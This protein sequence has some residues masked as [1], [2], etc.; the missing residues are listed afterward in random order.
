MTFPRW[1]RSLQALRP[2]NPTRDRRQP[3]PAAPRRKLAL[4]ILE[5]RVVPAA[6][7]WIA[8]NGDWDVATNWS[9]GT[10][11]GAAD[12]VDINVSGVT[13]THTAATAHSV[14]SLKLEAGTLTGPDSLTVTGQFTWTG[15]TLGGS[16]SL[17]AAGGASINGNVTLDG[18]TLANAGTATWATGTILAGDGAVFDNQAGGTFHILANT[19]PIDLSEP[20]NFTWSGQGALPTFR[21]EGSVVQDSGTGRAWIDADFVSSGSVAVSSG[22]LFLGTARSGNQSSG[23]GTFTGGAGTVLLFAGQWTLSSAASVAGDYVQFG[24]GEGGQSAQ[25]AAHFTA[26]TETVAFAD[27]VTFTG[28]VDGLGAL[29]VFQGTADFEPAT[30]AALPLAFLRLEGDGTLAGKDSFTVSGPATF[31]GGAALRGPGTVTAAGG[32]SIASDLD[33]DGATLAIPVGATATLTGSITANNGAV[34][35]NAGTFDLAGDSAQVSYSNVGAPLTFNNAGS[36]LRSGSDPVVYAFV[37]AVLNN[38][39]SL[40]VQTGILGVYGFGQ[41]CVSSG[42][43]TGDPGTELNLGGQVTTLSQGLTGDSVEFGVVRP[44][45]APGGTYTIAGPYRANNTV[46]AG[47]GTMAFTGPVGDAQGNAGGWFTNGGTTTDFSPASGGPAT[48]TFSRLGLYATLSGTDSFV[49]SG[50]FI[51]QGTL[52]GPQGSSLTA[53]GGASIGGGVTLDGRTLDN[54]GTATWTD[55]TITVADG[56]VVNNLPGATFGSAGNTSTLVLNGG[57]VA[58]SGTINANVTNSGQVSPGGTGVPGILT[59]NGSYAQSGSGTLNIDLG[60]PNPGSQYDQLNVNGPT[61]LGGTLNIT[62]LPNLGHVC[63]VTFAAINGSPL[64]GTFSTINGLSQP[65]GMTITPAYSSS[66]LTLTASKFAATTGVAASVNP[67]ILKQAV[68]FTATVSAPAGATEVPTGTVQFQVDGVNVGAP[69]TLSG[70][71][72]SFSLSSLAVGPHT[73]T[74]LY[75]GDDCFFTGSG[76]MT[77]NV[78]YAFGGFQAPLGQV[79]A[80]AINRTIPIKFQLSDYNGASITSLS[81]VTALQIFNSQNVDVLGGTGAASVG[82]NGTTYTFNWQTKGLAAGTYTISLTLADGTSHTFIVQ[83]TRNGSSAGLTTAAAGGTGSAPGGL[84]GGNIEL[85]VDNNNGALTAD[86]LARI[87]DAVTAADAVTEPYGVAVQ[88]VTDLTLADVTLTM[89]TTSAV[90]GYADG[91]LGCTTDAGQITII[92]GWNFYAGS[93]STQVGSAQYDFQTVVTHELGHALGLGHSTDSTS[94]M[95]AT[96]NT[97]TVNRSLTTADLNVPDS[98]AGGACGLHAALPS[99]SASG[100]VTGGVD[101]PG[102][103]GNLNPFGQGQGGSLPSSGNTTPLATFWTGQAV[104]GR[105]TEERPAADRFSWPNL[106]DGKPV[107]TVPRRESLA[108]APGGNRQPLAVHLAEFFA[109]DSV[110]EEANMVGRMPAAAG[111]DVQARVDFPLSPGMVDGLFAG[112]EQ[113]NL[114]SMLRSEEGPESPVEVLAALQTEGALVDSL[115]AGFGT[116]ALLSGLKEEPPPRRVGSGEKRQRSGQ[117]AASQ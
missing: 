24:V 44:F 31:T 85:Y 83:L 95:Y 14:N 10:V 12:D 112:L 105:T 63:G 73:I 11:P 62:L 59:I 67:S 20:G 70:G 69:V 68:T 93:D 114:E 89:D 97:G 6:V 13:I 19:G 47:G 15:G 50:P 71:Q 25:V 5:D 43:F 117:K 37:N 116:W 34:I 22:A 32:L 66:S 38:T 51:W 2:D 92:S 65:G 21:N 88:E 26:A 109:G 9:T 28:A 42:S 103:P 98:D 29:R 102:V 35:N 82:V 1:L 30:P 111:A 49:V 101:G 61:T 113:T 104:Q 99:G 27:A 52:R 84:L 90:G 78:H 79:Q 55:G 48:L 115:A 108:S 39:G 96:L 72:A 76:S 41:A 75:S 16:G 87:Q 110:S 8:G 57:T 46:T 3:R 54:A 107:T 7:T 100:A 58:G 17:T 91:V 94:V 45:S 80:Y 18:R 106:P 64:S 77:E 56:G 33:L 81:A 36:L 23:S 74:A 4:E 40:E 86:E 60:G 53:E